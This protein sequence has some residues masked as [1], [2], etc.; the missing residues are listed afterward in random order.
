[1]EISIYQVEKVTAKNTSETVGVCV[2]SAHVD[3][4]VMQHIATATNHS[5][6]AFVVAVGPWY[7]LYTFTPNVEVQP[8]YS[9]STAAAH[10]IFSLEPDKT[11]IRLS[12]ENSE[13]LVTKLFRKY[14]VQIQNKKG[15]NT[16]E[17]PSIIGSPQVYSLTVKE[18]PNQQLIA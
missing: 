10:V 8:G 17:A 4:N 1:M 2:L 18:S 13:A 9:A 16:F 5:V 14:E 7:Y 3:A 15:I 6:T 12:T 11:K